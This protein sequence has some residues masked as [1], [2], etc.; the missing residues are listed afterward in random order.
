MSLRQ[1]ATLAE[2]DRNLSASDREWFPKYLQQIAKFQ[3]GCVS[4]IEPLA[5]DRERLI[6]FL[7]SRN[8]TLVPG[9]IRVGS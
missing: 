8:S 1:S 7:K 6:E 4:Q 2:S 3:V 5:V 9:A